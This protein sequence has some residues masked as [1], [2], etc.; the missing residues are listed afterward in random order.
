MIAVK[1]LQDFKSI[2]EELLA[3]IKLDCRLYQTYPLLKRWQ[4]ILNAVPK[5][6]RLNHPWIILDLPDRANQSYYA[7]TQHPTLHDSA[8][9]VE[10]MPFDIDEQDE[11]EVKEHLQMMFEAWLRVVSRPGNTGSVP[12]GSRTPPCAEAQVGSQEPPEESWIKACEIKKMFGA[13]HNDN[14]FVKR[15]KDNRGL[16]PDKRPKRRGWYSRKDAERIY[17]E[18]HPDDGT[19]Q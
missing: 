18:D 4:E 2:A 11:S 5:S 12:I 8:Y 17:R 1:N 19:P 7:L 6:D 9:R 14:Q 16:T 10:W 3:A 15:L 13:D